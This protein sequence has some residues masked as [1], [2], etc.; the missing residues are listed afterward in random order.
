[1][2][3]LPKPQAGNPDPVFPE[4]QAALPLPVAWAVL[5]ALPRRVAQALLP[6][7]EGML[8]PLPPA[9]VVMLDLERPEWLETR[10]RVPQGSEAAEA[11]EV[12]VGWRAMPEVEPL[13]KEEP[14]LLECQVVQAPAARPVLAA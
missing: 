12:V 4:E 1:M 14:I 10:E 9:T 11:V 8:V 6:E 2:Q 3:A 7:Q 5:P 13:V